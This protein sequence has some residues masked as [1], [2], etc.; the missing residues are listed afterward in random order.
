MMRISIFVASFALVLSPWPAAAQHHAA[1]GDRPRLII[2]EKAV[3][4]A[5]VTTQPQNNNRD[6]VKNGA[7]IGA[8]VGA[9]LMGGFVTFLCN[10]L[11]E[12]GDPP[13]WKS[14]GLAIAMGAGAGAL[15]GAGIDALL[16]VTTP[17]EFGLYTRR[18]ADFYVVC[19]LRRDAGASIHGGTAICRD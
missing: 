10:A 18:H 14:S 12:P 15:G 9:A 13:C 1:S 16:R 7:I 2:S 17:R 6:S 11:K 4:D 3:A 19:H 8:V 5:L